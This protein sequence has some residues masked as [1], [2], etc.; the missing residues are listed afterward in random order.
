MNALEAQTVTQK[1]DAVKCMEVW[2]GNGAAANCF[3]R[4][5]LDVWVWSKP[6]GDS[7]AAGGD[8]HFMSSCSSGRITRMLVADVCAQAPV[9]SELASDLRELMIRNVNRIRQTEFVREM[10]R[11]LKDFACRG[12]F[13][14]ALIA[15]F[16]AP[17]KSFALCNTGHP[18]PFLFRA[19][20][21]KWSLL[22]QQPADM[23]DV[24]HLPLGVVDEGEYQQ[25][26]LRLET[27]DMVLCFSNTLTECRNRQNHY[28][29]VDG[30]LRRVM[31]IDSERPSEIAEKLATRIQDE[32]AEN[33]TADDATIMLCQATDAGVPLHD[34]LLA[35]FRL[36]RSVSDNTRIETNSYS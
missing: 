29:G 6:A 28:L 11:R 22:K 21:K 13:S 24:D 18:P 34:N 20:R 10:N 12:G 30:L 25:F 7:T 19:K 27:G 23:P 9:F 17:T 4:P 36:L 3:H 2:G 14:T 33:L 31:E 35:P 16:F 1:A 15:T 32:N 26:D 8:V 5:G